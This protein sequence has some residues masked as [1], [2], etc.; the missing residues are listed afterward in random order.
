MIYEDNKIVFA[1]GNSVTAPGVAANHYNWRTVG[2]LGRYTW[3]NNHFID[4]HNNTVEGGWT[5]TSGTLQE[6][7]D[8]GTFTATLV[9]VTTT[10][11]GTCYWSRYRD[12][13]T[14]FFPAMSGTSN[15][16]I[17]T[18][19]GLLPS[20]IYPA[21]EQRVFVRVQDNAVVNEGTLLLSAGGVM[22]L[23]YG[24]TETSWTASGI[25]GILST[26]VTYSLR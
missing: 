22:T 21:R 12:I 5:N 8:N 3:R 18:I 24:P 4:A 15:T 1:G 19:S 10:V 23:F 6:E 20:T 26:T 16:T 11:T 14:L 25:K 13:V 7:Y 9:G 2:E 17:F